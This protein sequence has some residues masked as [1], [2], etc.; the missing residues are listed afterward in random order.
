[1]WPQ[2]IEPE[3]L[4]STLI[5][6]EH[7]LGID[8]LNLLQFESTKEFTGTVRNQLVIIAWNRTR[9]SFSQDNLG[10]VDTIIR[11]SSRGCHVSFLRRDPALPVGMTA[12]DHVSIE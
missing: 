11:F 9:G 5:S 6:I 12:F 2:E 1:M 3:V 8:H 4:F 7:V 10:K